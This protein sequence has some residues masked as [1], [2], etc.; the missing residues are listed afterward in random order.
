MCVCLRLPLGS[1]MGL[2]ATKTR[3]RDRGKG[4]FRVFTCSLPPSGGNGGGLRITP[5]LG[6]EETAEAG[7]WCLLFQR[8][9]GEIDCVGIGS[10]QQNTPEHSDKPFSR[11]RTRPLGHLLGGKIWEFK[12]RG[13]AWM[14]PR[15]PGKRGKR[16]AG[17]APAAFARALFDGVS[18]AERAPISGRA[19]GS[20]GGSPR[21]CTGWWRTTPSADFVG[22]TRAPNTESEANL[23]RRTRANDPPRDRRRRFAERGDSRGN[24]RCQMTRQTRLPPLPAPP[25]EPAQRQDQAPRRR[26][27][28]GGGRQ[29]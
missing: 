14:D 26:R 6:L 8:K 28:W 3:L 13:G 17:L 5:C 25:S 22:Q 24:R 9:N 20:P 2:E 27:G 18:W 10:C 4:A 23:A 29:G 16:R 7:R 19:G 1:P 11:G 12:G 21:K 15:V